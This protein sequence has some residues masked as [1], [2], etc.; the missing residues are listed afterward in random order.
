MRLTPLFLATVL[1]AAPA[2]AAQHMPVAATVTDPAKMPAGLYTL[3]SSHAHTQFFINHMGFSIYT[4]GFND[5]SGQLVYKPDAL[6]DS[7]LNV[8]IKVP[9]INVQSPKLVEHLQTPD[10]FDAAKY[11]EITFANQSLTPTGPNSGKL[12]GLLTMHGV[13]KPVT[14][15]VKFLGGGVMPMTNATVVGFAAT[16]TIK[17]SDF[18]MDGFT[19]GLGDDVRLD[20]SA[21]FDKVDTAPKTDQPQTK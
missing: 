19:P 13:T 16:G 4:G 10:F 20:I 18:N 3:D 6:S 9:S 8:T 2:M 21:E 5:I 7:K 1:F 17:R 14:L 12:T 11:P 15:D